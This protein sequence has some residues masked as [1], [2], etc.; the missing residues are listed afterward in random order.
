MSFQDYHPRPQQAVGLIPAPGVDAW[1]PQSAGLS[2]PK[3]SGH[4]SLTARG[5]IKKHNRK[6]ARMKK[7]KLK[8][9]S[10]YCSFGLSLSLAVMSGPCFPSLPPRHREPTRICGKVLTPLARCATSSNRSGS[11]P[12]STTPKRTWR[13]DSNALAR[14]QKPQPGRLKMTT[15]GDGAAAIARVAERHRAARGLRKARAVLKAAAPRKMWDF[16][17]DRWIKTG[18][19]VAWQ[20][21][22]LLHGV[23]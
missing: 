15:S 9:I 13:R 1:W 23:P 2:H 19:T 5:G 7:H 17:A 22:K 20:I 11:A 8:L 16:G 6:D 14:A 3:S 10:D 12:T 21:W 18:T 4:Q